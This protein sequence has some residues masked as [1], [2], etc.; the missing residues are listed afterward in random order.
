[1]SQVQLNAGQ[2]VHA[3]KI[4][5][6]IRE[7]HVELNINDHAQLATA[8]QGANFCMAIWPIAK[9][10][11]DFFNALS[12]DFTFSKNWGTYITLVETFIGTSCNSPIPFPPTPVIPPATAV[13]THTSPLA[14]QETTFGQTPGNQGLP[15]N[16]PVS[17]SH[18][19]GPLPGETPEQTRAR[20]YPNTPVP[21]NTPNLAIPGETPEQA[22]ARLFPKQ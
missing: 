9:E 16:A 1:M 4:S 18:P 5:K 6:M 3:D 12:S 11:L 13:T 19:V 17:Q 8:A 22:H 21:Q 10:I 14:K 20:L 15:V 7:A 2:Q